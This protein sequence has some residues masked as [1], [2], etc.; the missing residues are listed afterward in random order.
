MTFE[1]SVE[2][3]DNGFPIMKVAAQK[4]AADIL[5]KGIEKNLESLIQMTLQKITLHLI[6]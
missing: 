5:V 1:G 6:T 2:L 3:P 4:Q